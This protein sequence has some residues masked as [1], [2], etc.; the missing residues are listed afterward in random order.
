M[1]IAKGRESEYSII[2][3]ANPTESCKY[4]ASELKKYLAKISGA[5]LPE[6]QENRHVEEKEIVIGYTNRGGYTEKEVKELGDEGFIIRNKGERIFILGSGVRGALYGVYTFL[7]KFCG[8]RF[9]LNDFE[10]VPETETLSIGPFEDDREVPVFFYRN[11]YWYP[12]SDPAISAKLKING[13]HG[14]RRF[15]DYLGGDVNYEG[16][17]E[18]TI[19]WLSGQCE[20]G[21][22]AW[23]QPCLTD[24]KTFETVVGNLRWLLNE[25]PDARLVSITQ[26]DGDTG[27]CKCEKCKAINDA[28]ESE[29]GT[30]L[31]FVNRVAETLE[32]EYPDVLFDTFAYRFT[33]KPPKTVRPRKNVIVR[34]CSIEC[35]F[36]HPVEECSITPG[37]PDL[38]R[39][40]ADDVVEWSKIAP[41]LTV[42]NY[43]TNFTDFSTLFFNFR[44]LLKNERFFADH[45]VTGLFEQGNFASLNG[46]FA[47]LRGYILA[48]ILWNP[49]MSE[50][51]YKS[52]IHE[53]I[54]DYYGE[55]GKYIEQY[56]KLAEEGSAD[57]HFG[58]YY[59]NAAN[60]IWVR[61]LE[62]KQ[63]GQEEF[64]R[65]GNELFDKAEA[66][67]E[68]GYRLANI[69]RSRIQL[70]DYMDFVV[71]EKANNA[72][73]EE[74]EAL[75]REFLANNEKRFAYMRR[76]G[77]T[78]NREF[79]DISTLSDPD[80][81]K[82][83]LQWDGVK[84]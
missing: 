54:M 21:Q 71:R 82:Y 3:P 5:Y 32:K 28:E 59:D 18:H 43:T 22:R 15:P 80:Y 42:W 60:Y 58:I 47:E 16:G 73:G 61:G 2:Y 53:F 72:E 1:I 30:M 84:D 24:E 39:S 70:L 66:A 20:F 4:A 62:S 51:E 81:M 41:R 63:A 64:I 52:L 46:E 35:C 12:V 6:F 68:D 75:T 11:P 17:F 14:R 25:H 31:T 56:L 34:L 36:N 8:V 78:H 26:N 38:N 83:A 7:E 74:K 37:H 45:G 65:L 40:F 69:R 77:I 76:Y 33:R 49:R 10:K 19:G 9:Y 48:R 79:N 29:M 27:A 13:C 57:S 50:E 44:T 23:H 67:A 55:G